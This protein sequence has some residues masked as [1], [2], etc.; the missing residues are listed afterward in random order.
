MGEKIP[1]RAVI[2]VH[3]G[4]QVFFGVRILVARRLVTWKR[5]SGLCPG[6]F[7][8]WPKESNQ[9]SSSQ[10]KLG[11]ILILPLPSSRRTPGSRPASA[12]RLRGGWLHGQRLPGFA[13]VTFFVGPKKITKERASKP[14][15]DAAIGSMRTLLPFVAGGLLVL[16]SNLDAELGVFRRL[17]VGCAAAGY[18]DKSF[19]ALPGSLSLGQQ[20]K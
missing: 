19:R 3:A 18:M 16:G 14:R 15:V 13:R 5:A 8:C 6:H 4:I 12:C 2:P 7:L 20:R 10:R 17:Y 11:P 1:S 9:P